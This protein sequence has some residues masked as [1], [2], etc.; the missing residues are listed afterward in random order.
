MTDEVRPLNEDDGQAGDESRSR[1][2]LAGVSSGDDPKKVVS[3][4]IGGPEDDEQQALSLEEAMLGDYEAEYLVTDDDVVREGE[5]LDLPS[6]DDGFDDSEQVYEA[7]LAD[8]PFD[9]MSAEEIEEADGS[10]GSC[11]VY[12][13][14]S[15]RDQRGSRMPSSA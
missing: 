12:K 5:D 6:L 10:P 3:D 7:E 14:P 11:L 15:P 8:D 13:S 9:G 4:N 1:W 2:I